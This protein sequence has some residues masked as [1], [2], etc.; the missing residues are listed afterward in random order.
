MNARVSRRGGNVAIVLD[1]T[2]SRVGRS[3]NR[4]IN[5]YL[6]AARCDDMMPIADLCGEMHDHCDAISAR[7][8]VDI[9][10]N[11]RVCSRDGG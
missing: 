4:E 7:L 9:V 5:L 3:S 8:H 10:K 1:D 6:V 11:L 2:A